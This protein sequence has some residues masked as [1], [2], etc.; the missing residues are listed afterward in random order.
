M[1][2][3][4][5]RFLEF[6]SICVLFRFIVMLFCMI[7]SYYRWLDSSWAYHS[8]RAFLFRLD[9]FTG[10]IFRAK[11][12]NPMHDGQAWLSDQFAV[13]RNC[14]AATPVFSELFFPIFSAVSL[15]VGLL[16]IFRWGRNETNITRDHPVFKMYQAG[17]L[18]KKDI[19]FCSILRQTS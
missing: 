12:P 14:E 13:L 5:V 3:K 17:R 1:L 11:F 7:V 19:R 9:D 6:V 8:N 4:A 18:P 2:D 10:F 15:H 16:P